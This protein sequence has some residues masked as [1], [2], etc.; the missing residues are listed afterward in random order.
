[1][2][3]QLATSLHLDL[4]DMI[5]KKT[6]VDFGFGQGG[7]HYRWL[8]IVR[9]QQD[10]PLVTSDIPGQ[11]IQLGLH[12]ARTRGKSDVETQ[13]MNWLLN[14]AISELRVY[15]VYDGRA[16]GG[17]GTDAATVL[18]T[19]DSLAHVQSEAK[20]GA[21]YSYAPEANGEGKTTLLDETW[22][23]DIGGVGC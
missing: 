14:K 17:A 19:Y 10:D 15:V 2:N 4:R 20:T 23:F 5:K 18:G 16:K 7:P 1:M 3:Q 12:Y 8:E 9:E 22:E 21:C 6:F 13:Q 11:L